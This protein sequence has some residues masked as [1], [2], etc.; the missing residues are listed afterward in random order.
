MITYQ[1]EFLSTVKDE[2]APLLEADWEEI[3]HNKELLP[4]DPDWET[5]E[6]LEAQGLMQIY[7][8]RDEER[9]VGYF[10]V[11]LFPSLH[12]K[13]RIL[14]ANDVIYLDAK[15]RR[16]LVGYRMFKFVEKCLKEDGHDT[17]YVTATEENPIDPLMKRLGYKKIET[18]FEKVL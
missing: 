14:A 6:S 12:S 4:L 15:Y 18:K 17:F 1:Q 10:T 2:V 8:V 5:Y 9:L 13:G 16:G 3:E 7:T 11:M